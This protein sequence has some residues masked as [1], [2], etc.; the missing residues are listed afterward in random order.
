MKQMNLQ[1]LLITGEDIKEVME[2]RFS[3]EQCYFEE[4]LELV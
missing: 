3:M 4:P 1:Q 2:K